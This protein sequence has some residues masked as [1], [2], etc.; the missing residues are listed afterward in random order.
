VGGESGRREERGR[1]GE[2]GEGGGE[3]GGEGGGGGGFGGGVVLEPVGGGD[4]SGLVEG[5]AGG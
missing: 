5:L 4:E 1:E 2:R 3:D